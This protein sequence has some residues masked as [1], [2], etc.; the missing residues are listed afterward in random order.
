MERKI[1]DIISILKAGKDA[2]RRCSLLIG[3]GCSVK[4]GIPLASSFVEEIKRDHSGAYNL[5]TEKTYPHCMAELP[6]GI[7]RDLIAKYVDQAKIN[8]A[9]IAIAQLIKNGYVDRVLTPN[10]DPLVMRACALVGEFPAVYDFAT[11]Q[12]FKSAYLPDKAIFHLHGQRAGFSLLHTNEQVNSLSVALAPVFEEAGKGRTWLVVGYSGDNDPVFEHLVK[13]PEFDYG[14]YWITYRDNMPAPHVKTRLLRPDN[15]AYYVSGYDAD[16]FFVKLAQK[17][18]CFPPDLISRPF[19]H[20][21][22]LLK[23]LTPFALPISSKVSEEFDFIS[24]TRELV[25][26]AIKRYEGLGSS[27]DDDSEQQAALKIVIATQEAILAGDLTEAMNNISKM[28]RLHDPQVNH[29]H[30]WAYIMAGNQDVDRAK[31]QLD[32]SEEADRLYALA[33]EKY[34]T[35][36]A[37]KPDNPEALNN[38]GS[39]LLEQAE[40]KQ[41]VDADR[42]YALAG[43]KYQAALAIKPSYHEAFYNW[44]NALWKQA[45]TKQGV[46][47]DQLYALAG[48]KYRAALVIKS[49]NQEVLNN[50]GNALSD[51]AKTK[52]G[53]DAD[54][55]YALADKKYQAA[56]AIKPDNP[57]AL[58]NW[59]CALFVQAKTKQGEDA[60]RLYALAGE[61]YQAA[62]AIKPDKHEALQNWGSVLLEQAKTKQGED[63]DRL[64]ALAGEKYQTALAIKPDLHEALYNWGCALLAQAKTKQGEEADRLYGLAGEKYQA[65]LAIKPDLHEALSSW[66]HI[67]LAQ[68]KTKHGEEADRL[69]ALADHK[70]REAEALQPGCAAYNLA[71]LASLTHNE[72]K[73]RESLE[74]AKEKG[75]L[76]S[77]EHLIN[78]ADLDNVR[79]CSWFQDLIGT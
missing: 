32:S 53:E 28:P 5:A 77:A 58:Y 9:H 16:E 37:I 67:L 69:Y 45:K 40:T 41:C 76:P 2:N 17:L 54:R 71:C 42:L 8:W 36:L 50:W 24:K 65:V 18:D 64:Y 39:T 78:D 52:Q 51:Q 1:E 20:V 75:T 73:A 14:L 56:L 33:R 38:W 35:A 57:E 7:R 19:S 27:V 68:A 70:L 43:D 11:S 55:L 13:V 6:P 31:R 48:E 30:S 46:D 29:L 23:M 10:F 61:K 4:A 59:G 25:G 79:H 66:G 15:C 47:A 60:Y 26:S 22:S 44:G 34:Q 12:Q 21:N 72:T 3:A 63:A 74:L 62:L 49:D